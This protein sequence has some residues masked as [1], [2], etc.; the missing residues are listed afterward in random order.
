[1]PVIFSLLGNFV[2]T[3]IYIDT[4]DALDELC[5]HY[6]KA[7]ILAIDTEFVRERTFHAALGLIQVYDG[8]RLALID[9]V[10]V[11][12]LSS[13]WGLLKNTNITKVIHAGSEDFEVFKHNGQCIPDPVLDTQ[14]AAALIGLGSSL[15]YA[16]LVQE[17]CD[18][19]LDKGESRTNWL[20]RPLTDAQ[21]SY[22]ANDVIYLY[23][24][25]E[26]LLARVE[27]AN[28]LDI[29]L[30]ESKRLANRTVIRPPMK[31]Y[32]DIGSAWQLKTVQLSALQQLCEWRFT[33][34]VNKN[35]ALG[36]VVKDAELFTIAK[37]MPQSKSQLFAIEALHPMVVKRYYKPILDAVAQGKANPTP[38][39]PLTRLIDYPHYKQKFKAIKSLIQTI[40]EQHSIPP[41]ML[42]SKKLIHEVLS[43]VWK[44]EGEKAGAV[45][46]LR[47]G[48]R[49][50][51]V[52]KELLKLL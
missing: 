11:P 21:L 16:K 25:Y 13:F 20:K 7:L 52:E 5:Q 1:M 45:P 37:L 10:A 29:C 46:V 43:D 42:A 12:D 27:E 47:T 4:Q 3:P 32:L 26:P 38:P 14:V 44:A 35:I 19:E 6:G 50:E 8:E 28:R 33:T 22:A 49:K 31:K 24:L 2:I 36:F 30:E 51:L 15:G 34:A 18:I 9:P 40:A 48:W 41:E 23:Q 39:A 17:F